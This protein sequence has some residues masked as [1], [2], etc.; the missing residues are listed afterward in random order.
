MTN[1]VFIREVSPWRL[2][3]E[4]VDREEMEERIET[5]SAHVLSDSKPLSSL[6][7]MLSSVWAVTVD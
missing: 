3:P 7:A 6:K 2:S 5:E 1:N 4:R